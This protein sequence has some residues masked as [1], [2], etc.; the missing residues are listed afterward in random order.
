MGVSWKAS[1]SFS[2]QDPLNA[3]KGSAFRQLFVT[4]LSS[5]HSHTRRSSEATQKEVSFPSAFRAT[6]V[7]LP[8]SGPLMFHQS[9]G[10]EPP[11]PRASG[12][13]LERAST[14]PRRIH[15][16]ARP[17]GG[18]SPYGDSGFQRV[19]LKQNLNIKGWNS[20]VRREFPGGFASTN[21]SRDNLTIAITTIIIMPEI[22]TPI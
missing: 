22:L 8:V 21:L 9:P 17:C 4:F 2:S 6:R 20:Q 10:G 7:R 5:Q 16:R 1:V 19:W 13:L 15:T 3:P 11:S 12:C 14:S 18:Q